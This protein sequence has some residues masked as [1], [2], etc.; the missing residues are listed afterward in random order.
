MI[1][2]KYTIEFRVTLWPC[3]YVKTIVFMKPKSKNGQYVSPS[4]FKSKKSWIVLI[5]FWACVCLYINQI[6]NIKSLE[7]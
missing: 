2:L 3:V 4:Q 7:L 5:F 6:N 1:H